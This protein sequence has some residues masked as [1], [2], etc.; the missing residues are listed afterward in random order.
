MVLPAHSPAPPLPTHRLIRREIRNRLWNVDV[1]GVLRGKYLT[2]AFAIRIGESS[3]RNCFREQLA[4]IRAEGMEKMGLR[5]CIFSE[6]GIPYDM[7]DKEAYKTGNYSSQIAAL[8][9]NCAAIEG[10]GGNGMTL[11]TYVAG[12]NHEWGDNW[13]GED[14]SIYS[15]DDRPLPTALQRSK[16][17]ASLDTDSPSYSRASLSEGDGTVRPSN[18]K[19]TLSTDTMTTSTS[20]LRKT[21]PTATTKDDDRPINVAGYRAAE[22]YIRPVPTNVHGSILSYGF[23]LLTATF[24]LKLTAP[25]PTSETEPTELFLPEWHFPASSTHVSV[26]GGKWEICTVK[27]GYEGDGGEV[28]RLRWWHAEGEQEI[29]VKGLARK[30]GAA[31]EGARYDEEAGYLEQCRKQACAVM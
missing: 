2:P 8:D 3:I 20:S 14:L 10:F 23:T 24:V 31:E 7:D 16:S 27:V 4:A 5:P 11:W 13:N 15:V 29:T 6:I 25:T 1:F 26:S 28:Q 21:N 19:A 17:T 22:A 30:S 18:L 9:A 12:N